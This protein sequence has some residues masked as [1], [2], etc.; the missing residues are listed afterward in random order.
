M[1]VEKY[2]LAGIIAQ[3]GLLYAIRLLHKNFGEQTLG[4]VCRLVDEFLADQVKK[5]FKT[6]EEKG[7]AQPT[8]IL[9]LIHI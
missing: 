6:V 9:S 1:D 4:S 7:I 3:S 2:R 8:E 5:Q